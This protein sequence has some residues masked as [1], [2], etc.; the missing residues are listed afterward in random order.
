MARRNPMAVA[1]GRLDLIVKLPAWPETL[2]CRPKTP[3]VACSQEPLPRPW[4]RLVPSPLAVRRLDR[5]GNRH[6]GWSG[7]RVDPAPLGHLLHRDRFVHVDRAAVLEH[8]AALC[9]IDS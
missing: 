6:I 9:E 8:R 1:I 5:S 3:T 4:S 2:S 7:R